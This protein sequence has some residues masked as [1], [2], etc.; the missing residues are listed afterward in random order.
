VISFSQWVSLCVCAVACLAFPAGAT[1]PKPDSTIVL[2]SEELGQAQMGVKNTEQVPLLLHTTIEDLPCDDGVS[3]LSLPTVARMEPGG[4]QM[5]RFVLS[6]PGAP[7]KVQHLKRVSFEGIPSKPQGESASSQVRFGVR[8]SIPM[9]ISPKGLVQ[10]NEP[11]KRLVF[12]VAG[13]QIH[14]RNPSPYVVRLHP[15]SELLPAGGRTQLVPRPYILPG[16][17]FSMRL[18]VGVTASAVKG[19]RLYPASPWGFAVAPYE[20]ALDGAATASAG[21]SGE[22]AA[23]RPG[24]A[25]ND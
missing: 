19:M 12:S 4:R 9:V 20:V 3:V 22:A 13:G 11:W 1:G 7:L 16:E 17:S 2:L 14:V 18:P 21:A 5:V 24:I 10:D 15:D 8:Q 6:K 23:G 25:C